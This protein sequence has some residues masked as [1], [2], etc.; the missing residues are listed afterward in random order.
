MGYEAS[1]MPRFD[2][3]PR[4]WSVD[5]FD[6]YG[7]IASTPASVIPLDDKINDFM[8]FDLDINFPK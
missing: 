4:T 7:N 6:K 2:E 8:V 1:V 3:R 5:F